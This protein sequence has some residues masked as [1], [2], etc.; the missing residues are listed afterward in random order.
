MCQHPLWGKDSVISSMW[1]K[2][3]QEATVDEAKQIQKV[4]V[5]QGAQRL[6]NRAVEESPLD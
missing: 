4:S 3:C 5:G 6:D 2:C 1:Q